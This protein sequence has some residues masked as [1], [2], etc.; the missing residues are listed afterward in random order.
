[1][2]RNNHF[3]PIL[4]NKPW[5]FGGNLI[6]YY[7]DKFSNRITVDPEKGYS[8]WGRR[9]GLWSD[10]TEDNLA[11][12]LENGAAPV[13][14]KILQGRDLS[15]EERQVWAQFV[16]SQIV[17]T[18]SFM[19]YEKFVRSRSS[20]FLMPANDRVG[21]KDCGDLFWVTQRK[22]RLCVCVDDGFFIRSDNPVLV[23]GFV[24]RPSTAMYYPLSPTVMWVAESM[25]DG[26]AADWKKGHYGSFSRCVVPRAAA[27]M[28]NF[29]LVRSAANE[30]VVHPENQESWLEGMADDVLGNYPQPP[31]SLHSVQGCEE[32]EAFESIR[33]LMS[34]CDG[35]E[36]PKWHL[37]E[38]EV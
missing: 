19:R 4:A 24:E 22:W 36:Y 21:C 17:R 11:N 29:Y 35:V 5:R 8:A 3:S 7:R 37:D 38:L 31:F 30:F 6:H 18:P 27:T 33:S 14:R 25:P 12:N 13:Y 2:S 1:M 15:S 20:S 10:Y 28:V 34:D 26:W 23:T 9:K 16:L 32:D